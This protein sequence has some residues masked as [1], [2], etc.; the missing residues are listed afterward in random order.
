MTGPAEAPVVP[1]TS[2]EFQRLSHVSRETMGRLEAYLDLLKRWQKAIN[3]VSNASLADPW[4]RHFLDSAQLMSHLPESPCRIADLGSGAGFPG[5]V[6]AI[7]GAGEAH[8]IESDGRKCAFLREAARLTGAQTPVHEGR[9]EAVDPIG[10]DLVTARALAPLGKLLDY[11]VRHLKPGGL[12][13]LLKGKGVEDELTEARK[14]WN[15]TFH[16]S[17]N[18]VEKKGWI[19]HIGNITR[20][21][22]NR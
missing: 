20:L 17:V 14:E 18:H 19:L 16:K 2:D 22:H 15:M 7:L 3:L 11:A 13:L 8:L 6:L 12:C 10:A 5:L 9:I 21:H 1:L 4:R